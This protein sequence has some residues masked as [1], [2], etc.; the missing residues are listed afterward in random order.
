MYAQVSPSFNRFTHSEHFALGAI[1]TLYHSPLINFSLC[2][3]F[4][5]LGLPQVATHGGELAKLNLAGK[6]LNKLDKK[7]NK[8]RLPNILQQQKLSRN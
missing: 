6:C 7:K 4:L 3:P 2:L 1:T 5:F 8:K